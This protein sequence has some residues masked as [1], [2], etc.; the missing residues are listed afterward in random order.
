MRTFASQEVNVAKLSHIFMTVWHPLIC[1]PLPLA[2]G[3]RYATAPDRG[4]KLQSAGAAQSK[5]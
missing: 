4:S 3:H 2:T 5:V 1:R